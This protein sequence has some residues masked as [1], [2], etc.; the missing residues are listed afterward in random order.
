MHIKSFQLS[1][2]WTLIKQSSAFFFFFWFNIL[3]AQ[4]RRWPPLKFVKRVA[5]FAMVTTVTLTSGDF[6]FYFGW[7]KCWWFS[8]F[9]VLFFA[10]RTWEEFKKG[11][12]DF[13]DALNIPYMF[14]TNR[15]TYVN[16]HFSGTLLYVLVG[17]KIIDATTNI[18]VNYLVK[19]LFL[20]ER[21]ILR[22]TH[23]KPYKTDY[24][25]VNDLCCK[26][27]GRFNFNNTWTCPNLIMV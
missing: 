1:P 23:L 22:W 27:V 25:I 15:G 10:Y 11:H 2:P 20:L 13:D 9:S 6:Y 5:F 21:S 26:W 19:Y 12:V 18:Y 16:Y 4:N 14:D 24:E 8:Y 7:T 3:V 17:I